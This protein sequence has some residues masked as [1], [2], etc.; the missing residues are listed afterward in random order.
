[1]YKFMY[2]FIF[3]LTLIMGTL[4]SISSNT[5]LGMWMGLEINMI[6]FI[7]LITNF[8]NSLSTESSLKYFLTQ[9]LASSIFLYSI[10]MMSSLN[11]NFNI[12][13]YIMNSAL[14]LK[15]GAAPFHFWFP[16]VIEGLNWNTSI[17]LMTW[18]KIAPL[19]M[20]S[21]YFNYSFMIL[22]II[23]SIMIGSIG[24]INQTS[25]R[26]IMAYSSINHVGWLLS[27]LL[28]SNFYFLIYF[29]FYSFLSIT[30][31]LT[32]K[33][34]NFFH[35]SQIY[36]SL[37]HSPILK[38]IL[39]CNFLSLGGLPPFMGFFP[40]WLIIQHLNSNLFLITIMITFTLITLFYY[41]RITYS[42]FMLNYTQI[43][44]NSNNNL[45]KNYSFNLFCNFLSLGGLPIIFLIYMF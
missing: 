38:F 4:I 44:F 41:I 11:Y 2:Y 32:F 6:S 18:Q 34:M 12:L 28:I 7:P 37:Q 24:G 40:K 3:M 16:E 26:K 9:A 33:K 23:L 13:E 43:K 27:S 35:L 31:I 1:M 22:I 45:I 42:A 10:I 14:M 29:S 30:I 5:W 21:Y 19:S 39:F 20:I 36:N 17:I 25:L 15:M 8:K